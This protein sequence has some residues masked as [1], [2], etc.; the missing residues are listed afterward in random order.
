MDKAIARADRNGW[1]TAILFID[2]DGF[3]GIND[4]LGHQAGDI[5]LIEAARRFKSVVRASDSIARFGGDEFIVLLEQAGNDGDVADVANKLVRT[6]KVPIPGIDE[7]TEVGASIG[8]AIFPVD[9]RDAVTLMACADAAMYKAKA[10]PDASVAF[11][12]PPPGEKPALK[13]GAT[14]DTV[15]VAPYAAEPVSQSQDGAAPENMPSR[16]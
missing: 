15:E 13:R 9:A 5:V 7:K 6:L 16:Q 10:A 2:L 12:R 4:T 8:V 3:K 14:G 1:R 11:Y